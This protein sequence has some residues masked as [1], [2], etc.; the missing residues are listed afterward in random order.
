MRPAVGE[1]M[2]WFGKPNWGV[3]NRLKASARN[4]TDVRPLIGNRRVSDMSKVFTPGAYRMPRPELPYVLGGG[5]AKSLMSNQRS[6][7]GSSSLPSPVRFGQEGAPLLTPVLRNTV[8]GRPV[9]R[10]TI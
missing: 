7:P 3:L 8:K 10:V 5:A 1:P 2:F 4:C 9:L 6:G